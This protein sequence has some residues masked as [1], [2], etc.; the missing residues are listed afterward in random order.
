[1]FHSFISKIEPNT[2]KISLDHVDWVKVM[3]D[4]LQEFERKKGF[5]D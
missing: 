3:Q 4:E 1:M 5:G 2:V